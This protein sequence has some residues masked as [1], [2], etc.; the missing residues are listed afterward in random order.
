MI[1]DIHTHCFPDS[2]AQRAV[3]AMAKAAGVEAYTD[4]TLSGLKNSMKQAGI[5]LSIL[6]PVATKPQQTDSINQKSIDILKAASLNNREPEVLSFGTIHPDCVDWKHQIRTL[7]AFG[8]KGIKMHPD[9]QGFFVDEKRVFPIYE[10]IFAAGLILILHAGLDIGLPVP[11]HCTPMK[12]AAVL[13]A[14]PGGI[15][16]AAHMGGYKC[17]SEVNNF[18]AGRD[19]YFDT[20]YSFY[21]LGAAPMEELIRVHGVKR[22]LFG[23]DSPWGMQKR[24]VE[25]INSLKLSSDEKECIFFGNA[26]KLLG[27]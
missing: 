10:E 22:I 1:I 20:S 9:Y 6:L 12:L 3:P 27:I 19:V 7:S 5:D 4:G 24:E 15:I 14:F 2:V 11:I 13:D 23:T 21:A 25:L 17:W 26:K 18:L 8:I 16:V